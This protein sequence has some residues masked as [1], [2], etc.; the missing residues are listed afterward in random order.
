MFL[1]SYLL[2]FIIEF[3]CRAI[4]HIEDEIESPAMQIPD[5]T[6]VTEET[7][8]DEDFVKNLEDTLITWETHITKTIEECLK[9]VNELLV[10]ILIYCLKFS[11]TIWLLKCYINL[12]FLCM[13]LCHFIIPH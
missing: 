8:N 7:L 4:G 3:F 13:L 10:L 9:K 12:D 11:R 1:F 6:D 5:L 2:K